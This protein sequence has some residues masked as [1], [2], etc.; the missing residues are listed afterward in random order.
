MDSIHIKALNKYHPGYKDRTLVWAKIY[1]SMVQGDPDFEMIESEV[2][3]WR[4]V[5]LICLELQ[6][7]K[8]IPL[9]NKYLGS[10]GFNLKKR[11]MS[12][13]IKALQ[14]FITV[15]TQD[16]SSCVVDKEEDKEEDKEIYRQKITNKEFE[17]LWKLY[18][19]DSGSKGSKKKA[20]EFI[21]SNRHKYKYDDF[22]IA[23]RRYSQSKTVENGFIKQLTT[24][25][26]G[27]FV[28]VWLDEEKSSPGGSLR[29][30]PNCG[31]SIILPVGKVSF[32]LCPI[33][34]DD[35]WVLQSID[36]A[37]ETAS[38]IGGEHENS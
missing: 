24:F 3:K 2:D 26:N 37:L 18:P 9:N 23:F 29:V 6:A 27:D 5:A 17:K 28:E 8:P 33:C 34:T 38:Q 35:K 36:A 15:V 7:Q 31:G 22:V 25:L 12:L 13:T 10:K 19:G 14:N 1:F 30:C 11:P 16:Q 32:P 4:Y 20:R 21:C